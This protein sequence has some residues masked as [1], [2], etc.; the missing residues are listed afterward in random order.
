LR[1]S[2]QTDEETKQKKKEE[3]CFH[4]S[5]MQAGI[6]RYG[7]RFIRRCFREGLSG[8]QG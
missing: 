1:R 2:G 5:I 3:R 6:K 7:L 4:R 8:N